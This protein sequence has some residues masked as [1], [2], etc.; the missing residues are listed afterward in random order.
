MQRNAAMNII[1]TIF[2]VGEE[3]M[4]YYCNSNHGEYRECDSEEFGILVKC[5]EDNEHAEHYG[6]ACA[7]GHTGNNIFTRT[8]NIYLSHL[9]KL[10]LYTV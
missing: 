1:L 6:N 3:L 10:T 9:I 5:Q 7:I 4:C 2:F 8:L